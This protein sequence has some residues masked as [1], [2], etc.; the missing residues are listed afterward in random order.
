M[1]ET[2]ID[3]MARLRSKSARLA[4]EKVFVH[5]IYGQPDNV[6]F[7][8]RTPDAGS[9]RIAG[10]IELIEAD[11]WALDMMTSTHVTNVLIAHTLV[12]RPAG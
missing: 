2:D 5:Q 3:D 11:G 4:G 1:T 10:N 8:K 7:S 6:N 12:F 9:E